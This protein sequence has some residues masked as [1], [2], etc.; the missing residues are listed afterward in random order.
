M[1]V[2]VFCDTAAIA[3]K[4]FACLENCMVRINSLQNIKY[5]PVNSVN[6]TGVSKGA[7][8]SPKAPP[9]HI[10]GH[11]YRSIPKGRPSKHSASFLRYPSRSKN[12][13][14]LLLAAQSIANLID[15]EACPENV[16]WPSFANKYYGIFTS[17]V[18]GFTST[19]AKLSQETLNCDIQH[20]DSHALYNYLQI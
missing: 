19:L 20:S 2:A 9:I 10:C 14:F 17:D 18:F 11:K 6:T 1:W 8:K 7:A 13:L 5:K 4:H 16:V 3:F 12:N 15:I